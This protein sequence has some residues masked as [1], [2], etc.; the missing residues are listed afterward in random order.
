ML[1]MGAAFMPA[2]NDYV[3][4]SKLPP[5]DVIAKHL[6]PIVSSQRYQDRGYVAESIG[7]LTLSQTGMGALLLAGAGVFGYQHSGLNQPGGGA[8]GLPGFGGAGFGKGYGQPAPAP[9]PSPSE[10]RRTSPV[11]TTDR[12][13]RWEVRELSITDCAISA[14]CATKSIVSARKV[15][16]SERNMLSCPSYGYP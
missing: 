5:A 11:K 1:L 3:E 7:P 9:S 14:L 12:P 4:V 8:L 10:P 16:R 2:M 6:T 13:I 15:L